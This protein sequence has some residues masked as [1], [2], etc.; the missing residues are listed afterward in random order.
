M[1]AYGQ[2]N[3]FFLSGTC[4]KNKEIS[5]TVIKTAQTMSY[6]NFWLTAIAGGSTYRLHRDLLI[7]YFRKTKVRCTLHEKI[8][9]IK[10]I[11]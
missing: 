10:P 9:W 1:F 7:N 4:K 11:H 3:Y 5:N 2:L 6:L 8:E